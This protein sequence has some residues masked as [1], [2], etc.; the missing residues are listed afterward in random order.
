[1]SDIHIRQ[2]KDILWLVLDRHPL[3]PLTTGM[4]DK[5]TATMQKAL[6]RPPRLIVIT[7]MGEQA[8]CPG[9]DLPDDTE[10]HRLALLDAAKNASDALEELRQRGIS[11]VALVKGLSYGAG[12]ELVSMCDTVIA[13]EDALF[14][15]PA[16][17]AKVFP[18]AV[19]VYL[20]AAIGQAMTT[21]LLQSGETL[22]AREAFH[23]GLVHQVL[24]ARRFLPDAEELLVMLASVHTTS[25]QSTTP[26]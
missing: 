7:G 24:S 12:C 20:P 18:N 3:N 21:R 10:A 11:T 14:R 22:S 2:H 8:F 15:L 23:L 13:R 16:V 25:E 5:L 17:N 6:Q 9:V 26:S 19:S 4:F 1:M